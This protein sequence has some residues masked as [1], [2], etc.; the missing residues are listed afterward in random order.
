MIKILCEN[1]NGNSIDFSDESKYVIT[2]IDGLNPPASD[3]IINPIPNMD[4]GMFAHSRMQTRNIVIT[5]RVKRPTERNRM[6]A[7]RVFR[8]KRYIKV[9]VQTAALNVY[10]E[11]YVESIECNNFTLGQTIQVSII[12]PD[13]YF[14]NVNSNLYEFNKGIDTLAFPFYTMEGE[15][16]AFNDV[17]N[18][19]DDGK[20]TIWNNGD[21]D[22]G[23]IFKI[24]PKE[25]F[26]YEYITI[27][28]VDTGDFIFISKYTASHIDEEITINTNPGEKSVYTTYTNPDTNERV[29]ESIVDRTILTSFLQ[30]KPGENTFQ[31]ILG[32]IPEGYYYPYANTIPEEGTKPIVIPSYSDY[33]LKFYTYLDS[34]SVSRFY[35]TKS[36]AISNYEMSLEINEKWQGV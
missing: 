27:K 35:D 21:T 18:N 11:G 4:G 34:N 19:N 5:F 15:P 1:E 26:M 10:T 23:L 13:A 7:Y 3:I 17:I 20:I 24:K 28:N 29:K 22:T 2:N 8:S 12:C 14:K 36:N 30:C 33:H 32:V 9:S 25:G 6:D 16:V 31:I